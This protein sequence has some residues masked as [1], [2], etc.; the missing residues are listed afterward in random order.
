MFA[1]EPKISLLSIKIQSA[2]N[3]NRRPRRTKFLAKYFEPKVLARY[4]PLQLNFVRSDVLSSLSLAVFVALE[5][6]LK[7]GERQR[8]A[9]FILSLISLQMPRGPK[10]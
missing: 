7:G 2:K 6:V 1:I 9:R 4:S 3:R 8:P 5:K 10:V